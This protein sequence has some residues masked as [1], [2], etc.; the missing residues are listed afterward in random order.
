MDFDS[1]ALSELF[2]DQD[3]EAVASPV[4]KAGIAPADLED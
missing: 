2:D 1:M 4:D 3:R